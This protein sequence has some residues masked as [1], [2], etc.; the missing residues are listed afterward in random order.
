MN[1]VIGTPDIGIK[2]NVGD[3]VVVSET[4]LV[5]VPPWKACKLMIELYMYRKIKNSFRRP[6]E[7]SSKSTDF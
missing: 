2:L 7:Y 4:V 1:V 5:T 6:Y 3:E